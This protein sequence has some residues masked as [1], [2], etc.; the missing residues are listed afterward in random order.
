M[1][2][3][4]NNSLAPTSSASRRAARALRA[5]MIRC[6][7]AS[8]RVQSPLVLL[9]SSASADDNYKLLDWNWKFQKHPMASS[10]EYCSTNA[11]SDPSCARRQA[12]AVGEGAR[13]DPRRG[14]QVEVHEKKL[15]ER[16]RRIFQFRIASDDCP[17]CPGLNYIEFGALKDPTKPAETSYPTY[18][19]A[20]KMKKCAIRF[21]STMSWYVGDDDPEANQFDLLS[22]AL[23]EFGHC[24]GLDDAPDGGAV[25]SLGLK[26]GEKRRDLHAGRYCRA[27]QDIRRSLMPPLVTSFLKHKPTWSLTLLRSELASRQ[28]KFLL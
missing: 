12:N 10:F 3:Q 28:A 15:E 2:R 21:N 13:N 26:A 19:G 23:R 1:L 5:V 18:R 16:R 27:Q 11:P 7:G 25:M 17:R 22:V 8:R 20:A 24:V 14:G 4:I 9:V 6:R